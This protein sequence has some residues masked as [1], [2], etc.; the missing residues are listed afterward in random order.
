MPLDSIPWCV[1][2]VKCVP[3]LAQAH[4]SLQYMIPHSHSLLP[5]HAFHCGVLENGGTTGLEMAGSL[6]Y[7][8]KDSHTR[9]SCD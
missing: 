4:K 6:N 9:V 8:F 3:L 1:R 2:G 7:H 5:G